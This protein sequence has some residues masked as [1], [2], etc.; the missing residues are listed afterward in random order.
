[1]PLVTKQPDFQRSIQRLPQRG[2]SLVEVLVTV[3]VISVGLLGIGALQLVSLRD[4]HASAIRTQATALAGFMF[5]RMRA[6]RT[7]VAQYQVNLGTTPAG[8]DLASADIR[9]WKSLLTSSLTG[10]PDGSIV[11]N[12]GR[13]T[14]TITWSERALSERDTAPDG[15]VSDPTLSFVTT[16]EI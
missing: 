13:A 6:N 2:F 10:A 16:S 15:T 14:V 5:D 3:L 12:G 4:A 8:T 9:E 1:V 7:N 11:I